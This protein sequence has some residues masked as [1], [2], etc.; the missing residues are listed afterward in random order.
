MVRD[1]VESDDGDYHKE[2]DANATQLASNAADAPHGRSQKEVIFR[3]DL[4]YVFFTFK[5]VLFICVIHILI[6]LFQYC[7]FTNGKVHR[8][9]R[10][11]FNE[12]FDGA[13]STYREV[14]TEHVDR[15]FDRFRVIH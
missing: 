11:L 7:R 10:M 15:M 14:C 5:P 4:R 9:I 1:H 13:W 12:C 2:E 6:R 8:A 3:V